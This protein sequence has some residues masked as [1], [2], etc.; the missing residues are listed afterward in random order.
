MVLRSTWS[1]DP[2]RGVDIESY[3]REVLGDQRRHE[4]NP[5]VHRLILEVR[6][7]DPSVSSGELQVTGTQIADFEVLRC[8]SAAIAIG[9]H[10]QQQCTV[11]LY[12]VGLPWTP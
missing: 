4:I 5:D 7:D 10:R 1:N 12:I 8:G 11:H 9:I 3:R 6:A 2:H